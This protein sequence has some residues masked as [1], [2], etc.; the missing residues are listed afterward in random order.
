MEVIHE[1]HPWKSSIKVIN[2]SQMH[3]LGSGLSQFWSF[4]RIFASFWVRNQYFNFNNRQWTFNINAY[5]TAVPLNGQMV[6][7]QALLT[8]I[9]TLKK[10]NNNNQLGLISKL[11]RLVCQLLGQILCYSKIFIYHLKDKM[12]HNS[13]I[14]FLLKYDTMEL[15]CLQLKYTQSTQY[16]GM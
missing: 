4:K 11:T 6:S 13:P 15:H 2:D 8:I 16:L 9:S 12:K 1:C 3:F 14:L 7:R 10:E 5:L